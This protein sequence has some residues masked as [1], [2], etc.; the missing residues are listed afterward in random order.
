MNTEITGI[1]ANNWKVKYKKR[2]LCYVCSKVNTSTSASDIVTSINLSMSIEWG[3]QSWDEVSVEMIKK[4]FKATKRYPEKLEEED[5]LFEGKDER[6]DL[7]ELLKKISPSCDAQEF[8]ASEEE[9]EVCHGYIN[10][11]DPNWRNAMRDQLL[12]NEGKLEECAELPNDTE[13]SLEMEDDE[14]DPDL[15]QPTIRTVSEAEQLAEQ[16]RN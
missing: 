5:D 3:W 15:Q 13:R 10:G 6:P 14:F 9:I 2:L 4:C 1:I 8:I 12:Y 16:L 11:T 7:L